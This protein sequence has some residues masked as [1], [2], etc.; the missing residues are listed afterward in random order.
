MNGTSIQYSS[1]A[2]H[3]LYVAPSTNY[4]RMAYGHQSP[5]PATAPQDNPNNCSMSIAFDRKFVS[6]RGRSSD[7]DEDV[8]MEAGMDINMSDRCI[9][10]RRSIVAISG[11][12]SKVVET[13]V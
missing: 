2:A 7:N 3:S 5:A 4:A 8:K 13:Q 12:R 1:M 11:K 6:K 10:Y 9:Y